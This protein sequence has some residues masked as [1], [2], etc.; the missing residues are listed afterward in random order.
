MFTYPSIVLAT[1]GL[2]LFTYFLTQRELVLAISFGGLYLLAACA[3]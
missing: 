2:G 1:A 3:A